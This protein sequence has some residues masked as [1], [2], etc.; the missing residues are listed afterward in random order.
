M[1]RRT[2]RLSEMKANDNIQMLHVCPNLLLE[3]LRSLDKAKIR[4]LF[5]SS[6]FTSLC[7]GFCDACRYMGHG[8][9]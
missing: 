8:R 1:L 6:Q 2:K 5:G 7:N 4:I 3:S 9:E